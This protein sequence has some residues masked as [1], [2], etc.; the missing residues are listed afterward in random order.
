MYDIREI[1]ADETRSLRQAILRPHQTLAECVYPGDDDPQTF[2]L[3]AFDGDTLV[4]ITSVY[5]ERETRFDVFGTDSQFRLRGMATLEPYR[6]RG[7]GGTLLRECLNRSWSAGAKLF[8]C[9]A[10]TSA[11]GYYDKMGFRAIPEL[12]EIPEIG[13][14]R[15]MFI[16]RPSEP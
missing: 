5:V 12:F 10:R 11:S 9:N 6:G 1:K 8:W 7:I 4:T 16:E 2:H 15:V 3:G 13:P 14:H